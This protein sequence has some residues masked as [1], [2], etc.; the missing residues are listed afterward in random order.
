MS[1][2]KDQSLSLYG[3]EKYTAWGEAE[4]AADAKAKGLTGGSITSSNDSNFDFALEVDKAFN[5]LG[6]YYTSLLDEAGGDLNLALSRLQEDYDT[7]KRFRL[8]NFEQSSKAIDLAQESFSTDADKAFKTLENSQLA[9]GISRG[10]MYDPSGAK[11]IADVETEL[12]NK[13]IGL[14]QE[15]I[16]LKRTGLDTE[17]TQANTLADTTL[18]RN[19]VDMPEK[20]N[21][22]KRDLEEQRKLEAG[23]IATSRE[24]RAYNRFESALV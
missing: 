18:A 10:S 19:Q 7:G 1:L 12:L 22:Y 5:E 2:T 17:F 4:A 13:N 23:Q 6:T 9:K 11:G 3:T 15:N 14:G 21:R 8:Q 20:Y 16:D 24:Q